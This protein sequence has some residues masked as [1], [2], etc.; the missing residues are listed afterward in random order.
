[1]GL[2]VCM[3]MSSVVLNRRFLIE[4]PLR[5]VVIAMEEQSRVSYPEEVCGFLCIGEGGVLEYEPCENESRDRESH[6]LVSSKQYLEIERRLEV[7][8]KE[9]VAFFHSHCNGI[10][11]ASDLDLEF[12]R[13]LARVGYGF[14]L[15]NKREEKKETKREEKIEEKRET[16][17]GTWFRYESEFRAPLLGRRFVYGIYDCYTLVR[18]YYQ[19]EWGYSVRYQDYPY[20]WWQARSQAQRE[21]GSGKRKTNELFLDHLKNPEDWGLKRLENTGLKCGDILLFWV[22]GRSPNHLGIYQGEGL[23]LHHLEHRLSTL[24]RY[25]SFWQARCHSVYRLKR[26]GKGVKKARNR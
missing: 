7:E 17:A 20:R 12:I 16:K 15:E 21:A 8:G 13:G 10:A 19:K 5:E 18:D 1:M 14:S 24:D 4:S 3:D 2:S 6:C 22:A 9:V 23:F 26:T 11:R 25:D